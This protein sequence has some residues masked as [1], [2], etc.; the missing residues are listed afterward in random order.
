MLAIMYHS[1]DVRHVHVSIQPPNDVLVFHLIVDD[2]VPIDVQLVHV[3]YALVSRV[4]VH[5]YRVTI[6]NNIKYKSLSQ[7][8]YQTCS[9]IAFSRVLY[10]V[11]RSSSAFI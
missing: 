5:V 10:T 2:Q 3:N 8:L 9:S 4:D 11:T 1:V 6:I 7:Y